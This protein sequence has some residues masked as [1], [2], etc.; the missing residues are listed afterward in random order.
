MTSNWK[1]GKLESNIEGDFKETVLEV[2]KRLR[3]VSNGGVKGKGKGKVTTWRF[4]G[5]WLK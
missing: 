1:Y 5:E 3:N 4:P 2:N